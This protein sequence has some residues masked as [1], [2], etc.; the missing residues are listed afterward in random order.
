MARVLWKGA[1]TFG[2]VHVPVNLYPGST[3]STL[4]FDLLDRRDFAPVG[5]QRINKRTGKEVAGRDREG[6]RVREGGLRRRERRGLR[7]GQRQGD[8]DGR[9]PRV[10]RGVGD[11]ALLLRHAVLP[12]ARQAGGQEGYALLRETLRRTGRVGVARTA[13]AAT[14]SRRSAAASGSATCPTCPRSRPRASR[15]RS[16]LRSAGASSS[17]PARPLHRSAPGAVIPTVRSVP[18]L[19]RK[20]LIPCQPLPRYECCSRR[21]QQHRSK[22]RLPPAWRRA[23]AKCL[24]RNRP[25]FPGL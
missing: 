19:A 10:R 24:R 15:R 13:A 9:D 11:R 6:L 7:A 22:E 18:R 8:A 1:I 5:Y 2:L 4:D 17:G 16:R 25:C 3:S 12:R 21:D 23:R 14:T 20:P